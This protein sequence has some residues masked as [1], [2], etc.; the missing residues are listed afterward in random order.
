MR[1]ANQPCANEGDKRTDGENDGDEGKRAQLM[2]PMSEED[3]NYSASPLS[4][5]APCA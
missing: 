3:A 5:R 2:L 4:Q 1:P